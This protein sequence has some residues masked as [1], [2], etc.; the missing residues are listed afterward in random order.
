MEPDGYFAL[1]PEDMLPV[2]SSNIAA[3]A[4][5]EAAGEG[6]L[7]T[8]VVDFK[9]GGRYKYAAVPRPVYEGLLSAPSVGRAFAETVRRAGFKALQVRHTLRVGTIDKEGQP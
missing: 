9:G 3:V 1:E 5:V 8:L 2:V 6:G 4:F 7:G